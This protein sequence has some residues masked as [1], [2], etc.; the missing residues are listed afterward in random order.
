MN[1]ILP[2]NIDSVKALIGQFIDKW[3]YCIKWTGETNKKGMPIVYLGKDHGV[4]IVKDALWSCE[5]GS[6]PRRYKVVSRCGKKKCV[7]LDHLDLVD[8]KGN[9]VDPDQARNKYKRKDVLTY[10][11]SRVSSLFGP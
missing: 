7:R 3:G 10:R 5:N 11:S 4:W 8:F 2:R 1:V 6:I 9:V